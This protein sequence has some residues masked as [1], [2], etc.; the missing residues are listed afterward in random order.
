M[1]DK[2]RCLYEVLGVERSADDDVIKKA[3]RKMAL[4]WH[5]GASWP[6][7]RLGAAAAGAAGGAAGG[8]SAAH[9]PAQ[10]Q[11]QQQHQNWKQQQQQL[12]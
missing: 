12:C 6:A 5:P 11:H 4:V 9:W 7:A 2:M 10:L 8:A 3:Y 1:A